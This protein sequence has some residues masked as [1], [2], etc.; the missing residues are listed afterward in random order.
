MIHHPP[1]SSILITFLFCPHATTLC[2]DSLVD[3]KQ[4]RVCFLFISTSLSL[5]LFSPS[6][7]PSLATDLCWTSTSASA[8]EDSTIRAVWRSMALKV[9]YKS[10]CD[11]KIHIAERCQIQTL[12][13]QKKKKGLGI[14]TVYTH[15]KKNHLFLVDSSV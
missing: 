10:L 3:Y 9:G 5:P 11:I 13:H 1:P 2:C 15:K 8:G 6:A 7:L 12:N 4:S 14:Y